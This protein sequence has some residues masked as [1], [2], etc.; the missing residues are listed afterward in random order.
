[1]AYKTLY[2]SLVNSIRRNI[3]LANEQVYIEILGSFIIQLIK[4]DLKLMYL[5]RIIMHLATEQECSNLCTG[6]ACQL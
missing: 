2:T 3:L 4:T 6:K 1:M 5:F